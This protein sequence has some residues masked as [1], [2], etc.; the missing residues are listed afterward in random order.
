MLSKQTAS[1]GSIPS[2]AVLICFP[3]TIA[4]TI[5]LN[6]ILFRIFEYNRFTQ[7]GIKT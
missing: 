5:H 7:G 6:R 4:K 1:A 2:E 3:V